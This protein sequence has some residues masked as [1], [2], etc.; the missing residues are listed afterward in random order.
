M[1]AMEMIRRC[2]GGDILA[3]AAESQAEIS[4]IRLRANRP[5]QLRMSDGT[6]AEGILITEARLRKI[7]AALTMDS[8]YAVEDQL[9]QCYFT[10]RSGVRVGVC[11]RL[12]RSA[13][14]KD[15]LSDIGSLCIRIPGEFPGCA[16]RLWRAAGFNNILILSP[17][18]MGKTTLV[19]DYARMVSNSGRNVAIA[20]ERR[21]IAACWQGIPQLDVG[22]CSDVIDDA[23]KHSAIPLLLRS[24]APEMIVADEIAL[25]EEADALREA[26][27]C[28]V[29]IAATAHAASLEDAL[30][31]RAVGPL[32][33]EEIFAFVCLLG[34]KPGNIA[35]IYQF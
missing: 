6:C 35:G 12:K 22:R 14:G 27:K 28:G 3:A 15:L 34:G 21:E 16:D 29:K 2:L 32:L 20:D 13:G 33:R 31:R 10:L 5:A 11:G 23:P 18:G 30:S 9:S 8:L 25:P 17:P 1:Q 26:A 4:E 7:F 19:R 24:C